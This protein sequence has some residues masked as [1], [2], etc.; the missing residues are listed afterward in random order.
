MGTPIN[1]DENIPSV[2]QTLDAAVKQMIDK[3]IAEKT[4]ENL[5]EEQ[6]DAIMD[7]VQQEIFRVEYVEDPN[8]GETTKK[9]AL[10]KS[11]DNIDYATRCKFLEPAKKQ[12]GRKINMDI[13]NRINEIIDSSDYHAMVDQ[14]AK[15]IVQYATEGWKDDMMKAIRTRLCGDMLTP[16]SVGGV[17]LRRCIETILS[18][19]IR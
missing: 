19:S 15:E 18:E 1:T 5:S 8:T 3:A 2:Q 17:P 14:Y 16:D 4:V 12:F 6:M 11:F 13:T 9:Y 7:Y 10:N